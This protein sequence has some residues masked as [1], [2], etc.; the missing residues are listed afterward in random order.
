MK[1]SFI[2]WTMAMT[3]MLTSVAAWAVSDATPTATDPQFT[4]EQR[5]ALKT[6]HNGKET[7]AD[8]RELPIGQQCSV[9]HTLKK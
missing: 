8:L 3:L 5:E 7:T 2:R 9:C 4:P 6:F 1:K